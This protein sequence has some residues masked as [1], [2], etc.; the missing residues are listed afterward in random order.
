MADAPTTVI[1]DAPDGTKQI[2]MLAGDVRR[3]FSVLAHRLKDRIVAVAIAEFGMSTPDAEAHAATAVDTHESG[4]DK[5]VDLQPAVDAANRRADNLDV[6]LTGAKSALLKAQ[7]DLRLAESDKADLQRELDDAKAENAKLAAEVESLKA[8]PP[9]PAPD[10]TPAPGG[11][12]STPAGGTPSAETAPA[13]TETGVAA[14]TAT[15]GGE[16]GKTGG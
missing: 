7:S 9:A 4:A 3:S 15:T 12:M 11:G 2:T 5:P 10:A 14:D 13:Q 1:A 8:P 6:Q 16:Q